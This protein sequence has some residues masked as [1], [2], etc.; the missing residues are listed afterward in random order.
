LSEH[1]KTSI[2][3]T[4]LA[5]F[6]QSHLATE[7]E[8]R[9]QLSQ[10]TE[11]VEISIPKLLSSLEEVQAETEHNHKDAC[12][13]WRQANKIYAEFVKKN[14]GSQLIKRPETMP[15]RP[16]ELQTLKGYIR[17]FKTI[18]SDTLKVKIAFLKEIFQI[19]S[20]VLQESYLTRDTWIAST[21]GSMIMAN[22]ASVGNLTT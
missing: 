17:L 14:P 5:N 2:T 16:A 15:S 10:D 11:T 21:T 8:L 4:E 19:S 13:A 20:K 22:Y 6:I 12:K 18:T 9:K 3:F 1:I 7:A